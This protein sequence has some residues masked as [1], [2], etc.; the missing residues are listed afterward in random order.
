LVALYVWG[1]AHRPWWVPVL[2]FF[3]ITLLA[4]PMLYGGRRTREWF[5]WH[6]LLQP[7]YDAVTIACAGLLWW[8]KFTL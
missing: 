4:V 7:A 6:Y 5:W 3:A 2:A 8:A 1:F